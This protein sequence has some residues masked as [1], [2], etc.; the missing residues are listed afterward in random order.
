MKLEEPITINVFTAT[1]NPD[2]S[3]ID[4]NGDFLHSLLLIDAL[5]RLKSTETEKQ[6]FISFCSK[7]YEESGMKIT[8][9]KKSKSLY[10]SD[11]A[12]WWYTD[13]LGLYRILNEALRV[14]NID[15]L[16]FF[17]IFIKDIYEQ[18]KNNQYKDSITLYRGQVM[19]S[20]ELDKLRNSINKLISVSSFF[21]SSRN[22]GTALDFLNRDETFDS[23]NF[24]RVLF[25]ITADPSVVTTK[26]FADISSFSKYPNEAEILF[27]VASIFRL[28]HIFQNEAGIWT[29]EMTLCGDDDYDLK[30]LYEHM[31]KEY[32]GD[33]KEIDLLSFSE[34]LYH[35][36]KYS[37]AAKI[38]HRLLKELPPKSTSFSKLYYYLGMI[39]YKKEDY[40]LSLSWYQKSL[41][42]LNGNPASNYI[43][44]GELY[45]C[46]GEAYR[47]KRDYNQALEQHNKGIECF[48][49][50]H[51][52]NHPTMAI[53]YNNIGLIYQ[54]QENYTEALEYY[55]K[56]LAINKE[57]LPDDHA[58]MARSHHSIAIVYDCLNDYTRAM[59]HH[60]Q[61]L[62]I[63]LKAH[64]SYHPSI[65]D[66]YQ[67]IGCLHYD[68]N[69][70]KKALE[71]FQKAANIYNRT[72][73]EEHPKVVRIESN[74]KRVKSK[75]K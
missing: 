58:D 48:E 22:P 31:K 72:L 74:I 9:P 63:K 70:W 34:V 73:S 52:K 61:S 39:A 30:K 17:H 26:P 6:E 4:L 14:Q 54:G 23:D 41:D 3:T 42:I 47:G 69:E 8:D 38:Y 53:I 21:S 2:Q 67:C 60:N 43:N 29:I 10:S 75:L 18:L 37:S 13:E 40:D 16:L 27:M 68:K 32:W 33:V 19:S 24:H 5:L 12:L 59:E 36:G 66:N 7:Q 55:E 25:K 65:A 35:M 49:K 46:I 56:S 71:Y 62:K 51:A 20:D 15:S 64:P 50:A 57:Y 45:N 44:I 11:R 1:D 28:D